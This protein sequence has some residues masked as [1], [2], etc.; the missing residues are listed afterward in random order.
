MLFPA[1]GGAAVLGLKQGRQD[2]FHGQHAAG[3]APAAE[4]AKG[5]EAPPTLANPL[6]T[7][8]IGA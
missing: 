5:C 7:P 3:L 6:P 2:L 8:K 4:G 1:P